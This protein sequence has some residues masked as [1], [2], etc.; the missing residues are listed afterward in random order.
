[1]HSLTITKSTGL[2]LVV[3]SFC[4]ELGRRLISTESR[5]AACPETKVER[6]DKNPDWR[7]E[8]KAEVWQIFS[9]R[10]GRILLKHSAIDRRFDTS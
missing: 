1:M 10:M 3:G 9:S 5:K 4:I 2:P 8:D 7:L 6:F